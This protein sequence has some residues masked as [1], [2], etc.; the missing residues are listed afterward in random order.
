MP[1][2]SQQLEVR[3]NRQFARKRRSVFV[4]RH[5]FVAITAVKQ[6]RHMHVGQRVTAELQAQRCHQHQGMHARVGHRL[7]VV[8][9]DDQFALGVAGIV[10]VGTLLT[11][12]TQPIQVRR[13]T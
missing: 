8:A 5:Q 11:I 13:G 7:Q 4:E 2:A 1:R 3:R 9:V 6:H 10:V 12:A